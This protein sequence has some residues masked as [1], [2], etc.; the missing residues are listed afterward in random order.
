MKKALLF[1]TEIMNMNYML[2]LFSM[3]RQANKHCQSR[4]LNAASLALRLNP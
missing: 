2:G 4:E 1:L 3:V